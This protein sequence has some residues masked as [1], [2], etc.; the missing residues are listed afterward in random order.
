MCGISG[1]FSFSGGAPPPDPRIVSQLN[2]IQRRRGPD[3]AGLWTSADGRVVLGHRRLAIIDVGASG[4]QPMMDVSGRFVVTFN[5]EIYNYREIRAELEK[6]GRRFATQSDT[7]VLIGAIAEWGEAALQRLRGMYAFALWDSVQN[8]LWLA[9]DPYGI[10]PLYISDNGGTMWFASQARALAGAVP[11]VDGRDPAG[12]TGF[13]L[14]GHVPEPFTWW[15]GIRCLPAGHLLRI[16]TGSSLGNARAFAR[17]EDCYAGQS[18]HLEDP[19]FL[20]EAISESIRYHLIADVPIGVFLSSGVDSSVLAALAV[21]AG[22]KLKTVTLAFDE[23]RDTPDDEAPLAEEIAR[24]LGTDHTTVRV[25]LNDF[26]E[27][28]DDFFSCMDQPT[29]DGLNSYLVSWAAASQGLKVALSGLGGDELFGGYPSFRQIP[30]LVRWGQYLPLRKTSAAFLQSAQR[31]LPRLLPPKLRGLGE[32]SRDVPSAYILRRSLFLESDLRDLVDASAVEEGLHRLSTN[33]LVRGSISHLIED[34]TSLHSQIAALESGWYMRN[35]LLRDTDW[36]GMR[37]G[38]EVRVPL[39]AYALLQCLGP[40]I[41]SSRQ[42]QKADLFRCAQDLLPSSVGGRKKTGFVTPA[43]QWAAARRNSISSARN[44]ACQVH[45]Q[46]RANSAQWI[47]S[48]S[49][50]A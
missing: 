14:W 10:K 23:F 32:L 3:G 24:K 36:A 49:A 45:R 42:P 48:L 19:A 4:A 6:C 1:A 8:E 28:L 2:D 43:Y 47:S 22:A 18:S 35:Q 15:A 27:M 40:M 20:R 5:G 31:I 38:L 50:A 29:I 26:E 25:S 33:E 7:E 46:F 12:L 13:Y 17:I 34:G 30:Q 39:V 9:R 11:G 16:K 41:R 37:F 44:W 21:E